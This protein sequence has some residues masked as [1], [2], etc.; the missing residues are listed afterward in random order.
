MSTDELLVKKKIVLFLQATANVQGS[1]PKQ[2]QKSM[3]IGKLACA[4]AREQESVDSYL[5]RIMRILN[6]PPVII[7]E[8]LSK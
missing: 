4:L 3:D 1:E 2:L 7:R 6:A 5:K 8:G